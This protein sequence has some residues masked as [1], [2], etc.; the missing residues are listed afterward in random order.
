MN[1]QEERSR[2]CFE[3][4]TANHQMEVLHDDGLYRHLRF[5]QGDTI[6]YYFDLITWPG[7]LV[8]AGDMGD[9]MFSR[10]RDMFTFFEGPNIN[11]QYW[12]EKLRGPGADAA[13]SYSYLSF[14]VHVEDWFLRTS[15]DLSL[16]EAASLREA[17]N[18]DLLG[19]SDV[20]YEHEAHRMLHEFQHEGLSIV[21]SWEWDLREY[22]TRF[23]W[24]CHAIV[25]GIEQ[26]RNV[27]RVAPAQ[28]TPR[29]ELR[30]LAATTGTCPI[31]GREQP[32]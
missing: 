25:Y 30:R 13:R 6:T 3:K 23:L 14:K 11:P 10:V 1:A 12:A 28:A 2:E 29:S 15:E 21:D 17:V 26:Y 27:A 16:A 4:D 22:D 9:Y 19:N 5:R 20:Y 7:F 8:V 24:C 31:C 32:R 18:R